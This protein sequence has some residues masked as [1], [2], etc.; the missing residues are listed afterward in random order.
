M[1][2]PLAVLWRQKLTSSTAMV[3]EVC[4]RRRPYGPDSGG[5]RERAPNLLTRSTVDGCRLSRQPHLPSDW[6]SHEF[7]IWTC[8]A[9]EY[10]EARLV[11]LHIADQVEK[12]VGH[13]LLSS[14]PLIP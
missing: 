3:G 12:V 4:I 6:F 11:S 7:G 1:Q 5:P 10:L 9:G 8:R 2:S 14:V 13:V